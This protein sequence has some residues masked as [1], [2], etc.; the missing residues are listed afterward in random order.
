MNY[1]GSYRRLREN[2]Q[3][4]LLAGIEVYN[5]PRFAYR[6][7]VVVILLLN[8]WEL[9]LKAVVSKSGQ[10]IFY[11]KRR[12]E[13]YRSLSLTDAMAKA[14]NASTWPASVSAMAV[15]ENLAALSTY[16]DNAVHFYNE[17]GFEGVIY[18]L[19]QTAIINFKDVLSET[20]GADLTEEITW[21]LLP[22]GVR[23][24][25]DPIEFLNGRGTAD[26]ERSLPVQAFLVELGESARRLEAAQ[27][28][29]GRLMTVMNVHLQS[30]KKVQS[31]DVV[32][33][34]S[35]SPEVESVIVTTRMDP[36]RS[37]PLRQKDVLERLKDRPLL[38]SYGWQAIVWQ[39][40]LKEKPQLCWR[41]ESVNL[42]KWSNEVVAIAHDL[43]DDEV[44][45]ARA[46]YRA[47]QQSNRGA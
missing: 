40:G 12:N 26:K 44:R 43:P 32:V 19:A 5:K 13:P 4:A 23:S 46:A 29:T 24:P 27:V 15:R 18:S 31:S 45:K 3:S 25:I 34:I 1:R 36:N 8:A 38:N 9:L 35:S 21:H 28:D 16:R 42:V 22:L 47:H 2:A 11:R 33:G 30:T 7:E 17:P 6:D 41:D 39:L 14:E 10:G 37:H 20:F